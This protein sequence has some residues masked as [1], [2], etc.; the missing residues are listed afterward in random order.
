MKAK[1]VQDVV[2]MIER[3][4]SFQN[5]QKILHEALNDDIFSDLDESDSN[6]AALLRAKESLEKVEKLLNGSFGNG[7]GTLF[8]TE[9]INRRIQKLVVLEDDFDKLAEHEVRQDDK[10]ILS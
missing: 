6:D 9:E 10:F 2:R 1:L 4:T 5:L 3:K 7:K 8:E